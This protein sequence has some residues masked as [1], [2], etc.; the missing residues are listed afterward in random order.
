[1]MSDSSIKKSS[2]LIGRMP[3]FLF[4]LICT[5]AG[6]LGSALFFLVSG[7]VLIGAQPASDQEANAWAAFGVVGFTILGFVLP[8]VVLRRTRRSARPRGTTPNPTLD[9]EL[10]S[11]MGAD[12]PRSSA[13]LRVK[14]REAAATAD[15]GSPAQPPRRRRMKPVLIGLAIVAAAVIFVLMASDHGLDLELRSER[16]TLSIRNIGSTATKLVDVLI[17]DRTDCST[18]G[19][20]KAGQR[21]L[22]EHDMH[23]IWLTGLPVGGLVALSDAELNKYLSQDGDLAIPILVLGA[24]QTYRWPKV[25]EVGDVHYLS[26]PCPTIVRAKV[27]TD[28]GSSTY[29]FRQ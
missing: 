3:T 25:L 1:M 15:A 7:L 16:G 12:R 8:I 10:S 20:P 24:P 17:N 2:R 4:V 13:S 6:F 9:P 11:W 21:Q 26:T 28:L 14:D 23:R 27:T 29:T 5:L 22:S 18:H 19:V